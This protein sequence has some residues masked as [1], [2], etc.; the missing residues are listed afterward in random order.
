MFLSMGSLDF[1][2][3]GSVFRFSENSEKATLDSTAFIIMQ[4]SVAYNIYKSL[5]NPKKDESIK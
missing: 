2:K 1:K 3:T 5:R 4:R